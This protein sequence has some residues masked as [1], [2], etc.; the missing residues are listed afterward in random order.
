MGINFAHLF[1]VSL[2]PLA[3]SWM[4]MSELDPQPGSFYAAAF[5]LVNATCIPEA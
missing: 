4:A 5:F 1:W 2:L 3:T